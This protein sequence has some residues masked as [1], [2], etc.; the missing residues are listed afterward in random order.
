MATLHCIE[1][2]RKVTT[3]EML[4]KM[5]SQN[6]QL[7]AENAKLKQEVKTLRTALL[8]CREALTAQSRKNL[9]TAT[10]VRLV[11]VNGGAKLSRSKAAGES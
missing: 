1:G 2:G 4:D 7:A 9:A 5:A 8:E 11:K 6:Y 3:R 10:R